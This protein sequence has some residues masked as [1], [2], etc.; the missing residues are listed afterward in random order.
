MI[1]TNLQTIRLL[2]LASFFLISQNS[3]AEQ[4]LPEFTAK[5][6]IH[7]LGIKGA[8]ASYSLS[9]EDDGYRFRQNTHLVGLA[10]LFANDTVDA[11]SQIDKINGKLLLTKY[12]YTQTGREKNKNEDINIVW[13]TEG[14]SAEGK[15]NGIVR[16]KE[17]EY[18]IRSPIWDALSFQVPLMIDAN[19]DK[20]EYPYQALLNGEIDTYNFILNTVT[21]TVYSGKEYQTLQM[22]RHD[23]K[24]NEQ[25]HI[26]LIPEL[27]NI[28][29]LI[30][31]YRDG[32]VHSS[33]HLDSVSFGNNQ[34]LLNN[35]F[36]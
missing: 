34:A 19:K 36:E 9:Y 27:N 20:K 14:D 31:N 21:S 2:C 18:D 7:Y 32:K 35:S 16:S 33:M 12:S 23:P 3:F 30:K 26:W 15:V 17:I 5:Y 13:H 8:E 28:P 4:V 29:V 6:S 22:T 10:R 1:N 24:K 11:V 25:L